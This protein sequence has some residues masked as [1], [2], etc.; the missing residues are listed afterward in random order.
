MT[1]FDIL[2][3]V[4]GAAA[5][6]LFILYDI[7]SIKRKNKIIHSFFAIGFALLAAATAMDIYKACTA[8]AFSGVWDTVF[9]ILSFVCLAALVYCLFFAL[10]FKETYTKETDGKKVCS[11]GVYGMSRHPGI[12]CFFGM[13]LFLGLAAL[14]EMIIINGM[15]FSALNFI[16]AIFQDRV[17]FPKI[18]SDYEAYRKE[19]PFLIP[20]RRKSVN[21]TTKEENK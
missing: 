14:P 5:F 11:S 1:V 20:V 3:T 2:P 9:I 16:Y 18:F 15:I 10:P 7:N 4:L 8:S 12:L 21:S 19:V 17:S 13:Y 6:L